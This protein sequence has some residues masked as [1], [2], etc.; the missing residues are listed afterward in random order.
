MAAATRDGPSRLTS[1]AASRGE[2]KLTVA[3][4][5]MTTSH[6]ASALP[7]LLVEAE[8]VGGHIAGHGGHPGGHLGV[9]AVPVLLA[10]PVEAV[11][12]E[13][14]LGRAL[15]GRGPPSRPD[16]QRHLAVRDAAEDPLDQGRAEESGGTGDEE[17]PAGQ[18][19]T[20]AGHQICLPYGK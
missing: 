19:V 10:Q 13:D 20:D 9:E 6:S 7:A 11:V 1:T 3:A 4:E 18:G 12:L 14:L 17:L 8:A 16:Q 5:W 15:H 2:S